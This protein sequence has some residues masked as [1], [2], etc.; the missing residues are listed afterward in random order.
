MSTGYRLKFCTETV[1]QIGYNESKWSI[2]DCIAAEVVNF[3]MNACCTGS[4]KHYA[5]FKKRHLKS[6]SYEK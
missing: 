6:F 5:W 1:K 2:L 3:V 4:Q